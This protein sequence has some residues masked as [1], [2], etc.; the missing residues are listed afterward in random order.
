MRH[1]NNGL[2][3][4]CGCPRQKWPKCQHGWHF[5]FRW[6][7]VNHRLS[8]DREC[9]RHIETNPEATTEAERIRI[10]I[11]EGRYGDSARPPA[12]DE[13]TFAQF[14]NVWEERRGK[15]LAN[16][17]D[18]KHRL[19][20]VV[21]FPLPSARPPLTFGQKTL[22]SITTDDVEAY[23]DH[24]KA[25]GLS[26]VTVNHDLRLL[27]KMFNWGIRKGY[28]EQT[29]FKIGT[30]PAISLE[31]EIPR[32]R[33]FEGDND[34]QKLLAAAN[35]Q[36]RAVIIAMLDTACRPGEIL[37]IKVRDVSVARRELTIRAATEK[38]RRERIL[39]ISK[40]LL[41]VL[42]LRLLDP[43]G[44]PLPLEAYVFGDPLG[45]RVKSV[46]TAWNNTCA[47]I[48]LEGFQLRDLRHEAGSRFDEAGI[49]IN[50][51]SN[52]LGHTNLTTT[53]RYLNI[54]RRELHRVMHRYEESRAEFAQSLH[55]D[56][57]CSQAFVQQANDPTVSNSQKTQG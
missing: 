42:E 31:R 47:A 22:S 7:G 38:T 11:R 33:R 19:K 34:E 3:K 39:P 44:R 56:T 17:S 50:Y 9:G 2:R 29:P 40:R 13:P 36:L 41:A 5:N 28:L 10:A 35:P 37:N 48:G 32:H 6:K 51:V 27:R 57:E 20:K 1:R 52:M 8:L 54:N 53:S 49:P 14:A 25:Q 26:P 45:R 23:W 55:R 4:R 46:G 24:R 15:E 30:E 43:A 18:N 16:A 12:P 21:G